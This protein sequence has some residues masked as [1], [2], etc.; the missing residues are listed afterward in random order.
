MNQP[1]INEFF[2]GG[3]NNRL[4]D[5]VSVDFSLPCPKGEEAEDLL[6]GNDFDVDKKGISSKSVNI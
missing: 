2:I 1:N 4:N 5:K 6:F 3:E